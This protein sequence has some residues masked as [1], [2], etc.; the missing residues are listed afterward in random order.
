[1][2]GVFLFFI[3]LLMCMHAVLSPPLR[4]LH[5]A[6]P[7]NMMNQKYPNY[8]HYWCAFVLDP[9]DTTKEPYKTALSQ[10]IDA[11]AAQMKS[12][13]TTFASVVDTSTA[14]G[15]EPCADYATGECRTGG[16]PAPTPPPP[17]PPAPPAPPGSGKCTF[18]P[19]TGFSKGQAVPGHRND[20]AATEQAC[21]DLCAAIPECSGAAFTNGQCYYK[22]KKEMVGHPLQGVTGVV[23]DPPGPSPPGPAPPQPPSPPSPTPT[24]G[25]G[26]CTFEADTGFEKGKQIP[27]HR[28]DPAAGEKC[29]RITLFSP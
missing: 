21:C 18:L 22:T 9:Q 7:K 23:R 4:C 1:L 16:G 26:K 3:V 28:N 24:P 25:A 20:S 8:F 29:H 17:A 15:A 5:A 14:P 10:I 12:V 13:N 19:N 27:G 2:T 6:I 11:L